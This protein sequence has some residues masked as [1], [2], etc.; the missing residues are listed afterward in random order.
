MFFAPH[1][2]PLHFLNGQR[3]AYFGALCGKKLE[4][5]VGRYFDNIAVAVFDPVCPVALQNP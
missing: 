1:H 2:C 5:N 4:R 3:F